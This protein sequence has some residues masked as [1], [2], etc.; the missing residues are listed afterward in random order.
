MLI[1]MK[2]KCIFI[3][4]FRLESYTGG[5]GINIQ[6]NVTTCLNDQ[7]KLAQYGEQRRLNEVEC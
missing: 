1:I 4:V 7:S 3:H 2:E 6:P 5:G